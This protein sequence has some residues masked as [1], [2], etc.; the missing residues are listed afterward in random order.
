MAI[1]CFSRSIPTPPFVP[2]AVPAP[3]RPVPAVFFSV[4]FLL[5]HVQRP[6]KR[7]I[8][9]KRS[10]FAF[11]ERCVVI[12]PWS[13]GCHSERSGAKSKNPHPPS[14]GGPHK[15]SFVQKRG[16]G[17]LTLIRRR[18]RFFKSV[19]TIELYRLPRRLHGRDKI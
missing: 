2:P 19:P 1:Y 3:R 14:P 18:R 8:I 17:D 12:R 11:C 7:T 13:E 10:G 6:E 5:Y 15:P 9:K 4:F 16:R